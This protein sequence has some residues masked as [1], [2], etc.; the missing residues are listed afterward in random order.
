MQVDYF[1]GSDVGRHRKHNED[2][3]L[4]SPK[5]NLFLLADGIGGQAAGEIAS[6]IAI[7]AIEEF[8]VLTRSEDI[9][10]PL[11]YRKEYT[12]EQN[13]L[14]AAAAQANRKILKLANE[15]PLLKGMGTTLVGALVEGNNL[16]VIHIG[17]SR[18]YRV[19]NSE[20][21]Q[22]TEDH[23]LVGEQERNGLLTKEEAASHPHRHILTSALGIGAIQDIKIDLS[24]TEILEKDLYLL[25]S[26]GLSDML[27]NREI[28]KVINSTD[29]SLEKLGISLIQQANAAGGQDNITVILLYFH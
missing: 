13:R 6:R 25:C 19:R 5:E 27:D 18:L 16:A 1:G 9:T 12:M 21:I 23:T 28:L 14:L 17:D 15:N 11:P 26:D 7:E 10:W 4:C 2:S 29:S 8:I 24:I 3:Y 20:L 22:I